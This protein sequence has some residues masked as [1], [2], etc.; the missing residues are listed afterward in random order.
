M[1]RN[2]AGSSTIAGGDSRGPRLTGAY[3][4]NDAAGASKQGQ[5]L[6]SACPAESQKWSRMQWQDGMGVKRRG[7]WLFIAK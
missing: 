7:I 1:G 6:S 4:R 2:W 3:S 5:M